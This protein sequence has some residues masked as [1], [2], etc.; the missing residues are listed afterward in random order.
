MKPS[1][2]I[3]IDGPSASGKSTVARR[4]AV[5]L[6]WLYVDSG[7]LYRGVTWAALGKGVG[8][9]DGAG[10]DALLAGMDVRFR[11]E[12]GAVRFTIDGTDPGL[13]LRGAAVNRGVSEV[14]AVPAVRRRVVAWLREMRALGP[15]VMEGR[16]IGTA[17]F[18]DTPHK[19]YLDASPEER[20][21]RR[22][23]EETGRGVAAT[24]DGVHD[25]LKHRDRID[26]SRKLDPLKVSAD[27]VVIDSTGMS[28]DGVVDRIVR[29]VRP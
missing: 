12:E 9:E 11:V 20:A 5:A 4:A 14:S 28:I 29:S 25:S 23:A 7:A 27:A 26:S 1:P 18:P 19:F 24:L 15:L 13:E 10:M 21:R 2:V 17:V 6:G 16:D 8:P 3:A 22:H